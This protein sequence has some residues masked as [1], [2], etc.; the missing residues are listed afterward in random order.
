MARRSADATQYTTYLGRAGPP[1]PLVNRVGKKTS[2]FP[3]SHTIILVITQILQK[4][5][6][7]DFYILSLSWCRADKFDRRPPV[8]PGSTGVGGLGTSPGGFSPRLLCT[9]CFVLRAGRYIWVWIL[10]FP[11]NY[12]PNETGHTGVHNRE[13]SVCMRSVVPAHYA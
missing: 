5:L 11:N 7:C 12:L 8:P 2:F 13:C 9:S 3:S 4:Y 6:F 10:I 1:G